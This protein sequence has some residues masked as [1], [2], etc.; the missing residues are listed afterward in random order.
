[1]E[2]GAAAHRS[3]PRCKHVCTAPI[4]A[5]AETMRTGTL[6]PRVIRTCDHMHVHMCKCM[7]MSMCMQ[8]LQHL[9]PK[10]VRTCRVYVGCGVCGGAA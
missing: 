9:W 4:C 1:M 6:S 2:E 7:S 8:R 10:G 3:A 5:A